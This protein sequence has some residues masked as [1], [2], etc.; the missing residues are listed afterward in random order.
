MK[1]SK[2]IITFILKTFCLI[3]WLVVSGFAFIVCQA[4]DTTYILDPNYQL[5]K[6]PG[7]LIRLEPVY[8]DDNND[9][10]VRYIHPLGFRSSDAKVFAVLDKFI[11]GVTS[12]GWFAINRDTHEVWYPHK[13]QED[14]KEASG[15]AFSESELKT[16]R[17]LARMVIYLRTKVVLPLI[18]LFFIICLVGIRRIGR[19]VV[20]PFNYVCR[21]LKKQTVQ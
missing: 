16:S 20:S 15:V 5:W 21:A 11:V 19:L 2:L 3:I 18:A 8:W 12:E 7:K 4:P 14:L 10:G 17:P 13:S 9:V 1:F 6:W